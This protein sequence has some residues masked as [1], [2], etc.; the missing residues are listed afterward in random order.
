MSTFAGT[1]YLL[2]RHPVERFGRP[3][4]VPQPVLYLCSPDAGFSTGVAVPLDG[5]LSA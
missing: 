5:G 3:E 2:A 1:S 4:E